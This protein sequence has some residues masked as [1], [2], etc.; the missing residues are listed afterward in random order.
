MAANCSIGPCGFFPSRIATLSGGSTAISTQV[1][2][3]G[4]Q[5][6]LCH[7][8]VLRVSEFMDVYIYFY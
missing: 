2:A 6:D 1:A 4:Q 7:E 3:L 8:S 5:L